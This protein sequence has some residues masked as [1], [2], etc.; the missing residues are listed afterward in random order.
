MV[1][2]S[3]S[4]Q[5]SVHVKTRDECCSSGLHRD[6]HYITSLLVTGTVGSRAPPAHLPMTRSCVV[7]S[8]A[9]GKGR[10]I[11]RDLDRRGGTVP[12]S[13]SSAGPRKKSC[14]WAGAI[15]AQKQTGQ[16]MYQKQVWGEG[17]GSICGKVQYDSAG[18][19]HSTESQRVSGCIKRHVASWLTEMSLTL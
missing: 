5:L 6:Q 15:P 4:H 18:C 17:L 7:P 16:R 11:Q 10:G 9:G 1:S 3:H 14:T 13:W 8:R 19:A 12:A 2:K